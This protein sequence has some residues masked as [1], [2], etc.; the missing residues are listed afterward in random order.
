MSRK[1]KYKTNRNTNENTNTNTNKNTNMNTKI[2]ITWKASLV[3]FQVWPSLEKKARNL[4]GKNG[5][6]LLQLT[7][8]VEI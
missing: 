8:D 4:I 2:R 1:T 7:I 3:E 6:I 5:E